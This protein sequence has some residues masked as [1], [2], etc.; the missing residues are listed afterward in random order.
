AAAS[1]HASV[2]VVQAG[3]PN[4]DVIVARG[5]TDDDK[6]AA[7]ELIHYVQRCTGAELPLRAQRSA[8]R[9][10]IVIGLAAAPEQM[11][12][13]VQRLGRDGFVVEAGGDTIVLAGNAREG[14]SFAVYE[15]LERFAGV[16]W[17]WPGDT[18]EVTPRHANLVVDDTSLAREP[19]FVWR[20]LG[21]GGALW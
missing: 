6:A 17:L 8:G 10:A 5:A 15:F 18:G 3:A 12:N 13:R 1:V 2:V 21:P 7:Y 4:A 20:F 16:R 14:T 11:R 19:A 9:P